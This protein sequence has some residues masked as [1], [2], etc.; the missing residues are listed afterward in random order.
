M[1]TFF[2]FVVQII[3]IMILVNIVSSLLKKKFRKKEAPGS[4]AGHPAQDRFDPTGKNIADGEY[5]D[6][7]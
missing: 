4:H 2:A 3:A 1:I 7:K 6:I 5:K